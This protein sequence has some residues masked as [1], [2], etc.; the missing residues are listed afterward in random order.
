MIRG[1]I[2]QR[3]GKAVEPLPFLS[4]RSPCE[5]SSNTTQLLRSAAAEVTLCSDYPKCSEMA[6]KSLALTV[7]SK[8]VSHAVRGACRIRK[9]VI[10]YQKNERGR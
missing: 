10:A 5:D 2:L 7:D 4:G 6:M 1:I 8:L 3:A 9:K